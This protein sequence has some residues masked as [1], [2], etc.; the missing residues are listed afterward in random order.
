M[1]RPPS[2]GPARAFT[3]P[4][5]MRSASMSRPESV[6]SRTAIFGSRG[7]SCRI[8]GPL[9]S[10]PREALIQV[11]AGEFVRHVQQVHLLFEQLAELRDR[12]SLVFRIDGLALG[13]N[14]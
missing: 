8:S 6:S 5:T 4:A 12:H 7:A 14:R 1:M 10:P 3:P 13:I 2:P 11:A 9:F